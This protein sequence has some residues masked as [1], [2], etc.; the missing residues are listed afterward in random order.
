LTFIWA[1]GAK[2]QTNNLKGQVKKGRKK[3]TTNKDA[4]RLGG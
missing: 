2:K 3:R 1:N 4:A